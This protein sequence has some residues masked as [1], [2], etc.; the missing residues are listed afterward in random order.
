MRSTLKKTNL[1][2]IPTVDEL[3]DLTLPIRAKDIAIK[4]KNTCDVLFEL[5]EDEIEVSVWQMSVIMSLINRFEEKYGE[6]KPLT[7]RE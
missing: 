5:G 1:R 4:Y 6:R 3:P 7:C 2:L